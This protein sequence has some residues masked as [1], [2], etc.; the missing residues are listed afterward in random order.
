MSDDHRQHHEHALAAIGRLDD[1][2]RALLTMLAAGRYDREI[3]GDLHVSPRTVKRRVAN[4][5]E[6]LGVERRIEAAYLAGEAH[7][8]DGQVVRHRPA[9]E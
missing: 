5:L 2:A 9:A 1:D 6:A 8:L 7:L 3:A 4:L